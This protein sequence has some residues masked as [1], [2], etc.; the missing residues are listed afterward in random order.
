MIT[1]EL[2]TLLN[3]E[4]LGSLC[5]EDEKMKLTLLHINIWKQVLILYVQRPQGFTLLLWTCLLWEFKMLKYLYESN[6]PLT[7]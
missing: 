4:N 6:P 2:V 7:L 3:R 1:L 5:L